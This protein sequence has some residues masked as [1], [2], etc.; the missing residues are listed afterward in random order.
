[1][2]SKSTPFT[3]SSILFRPQRRPGL[4]AGRKL[5]EE[6]FTLDRMAA[7]TGALA[8]MVVAGHHAY[9]AWVDLSGSNARRVKQPRSC[10]P[11]RRSFCHGFPAHPSM[12]PWHCP[13][14][15]LSFQHRYLKCRS[16]FNMAR[17]WSCLLLS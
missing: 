12:R 13:I 1:M 17:P 10:L 9:V 3:P 11:A 2:P 15:Y 8:E 14:T 16:K 5:V 7:E 6:R 4:P